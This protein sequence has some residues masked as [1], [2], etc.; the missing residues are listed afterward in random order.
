MNEDDVFSALVGG[1]PSDASKQQALAQTLRGQN[2]M[3][4]VLSLTGD[5][6]LGPYGKGMQDAAMHSAQGVA[7][8]REKAATLAETKAYR[9]ASALQAQNA[10]AEEKRWHDM[11]QTMLGD[12]LDMALQIKQ[13]K[14]GKPLS[15]SAQKELEAQGDTLSG[16]NDALNSFKP[17]YAGTGLP[18][19][20]SLANTIAGNVPAL[21]TQNAKDAQ[22][23]WANYNRVF[24]LPEIHRLFGA[25][26]TAPEQER[27]SKAHIT[28]N[29]TPEQIQQNLP[30]LKSQFQRMMARRLHDYA[31]QGYDVG[32][33]ASQFQVGPEMA[34]E[35]QGATSAGMKYL[36]SVRQPQAQSPDPTQMGDLFSGFSQ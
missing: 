22:N 34:A 16:I 9:D 28:E 23:W 17:E 36:R 32:D 27:F 3:G 33:V 2:K 21:A 31:S 24:S 7:G 18:G 14:A 6:V 15:A 13:G 25:R 11:Q 20:R 5:R 35:P 8:D 10:L 4:Q 19:G 30:Q 26:F 29:M 12:K 1:A